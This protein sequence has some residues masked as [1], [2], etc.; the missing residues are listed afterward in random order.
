[1]TGY[2]LR[3][4]AQ[5]VPAISGI[6]VIA[7]ALVQLAPGDAALYIAGDGASPEVLARVRAEF[8]LDR[9][10]HVQFLAY[11]GNLARGNL[12]HSYQFGEP[13]AAVLLERAPY[14]LLLVVSALVLGTAAGLT[15]GVAAAWRHGSL[16]DHGISLLALGG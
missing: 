9:P 4:I 6:A 11:L 15:L 1:V 12:G 10:A 16:I 13:V 3:R 14:S 5:V 2:C 7:F 8:G